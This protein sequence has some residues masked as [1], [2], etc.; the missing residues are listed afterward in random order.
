MISFIIADYIDNNGQEVEEVQT[1][2][3][4]RQE[5]EGRVGLQLNPHLKP[6]LPVLL[7]VAAGPASRIVRPFL[8]LDEG[9]TARSLQDQ[10]LDP[11]PPRLPSQNPKPQL[12]AVD[13][14]DAKGRAE[15]GKGEIVAVAE[16]TALTGG[17]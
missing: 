8:G 3:L 11:Q 10:R 17:A 14:D 5:G 1:Q 16:G 13:G 4:L 7:R 6:H 9:E 2:A 12:H 15:P